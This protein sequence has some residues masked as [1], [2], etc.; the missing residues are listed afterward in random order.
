MLNFDIAIV[1]NNVFFRD[2]YN[3]FW[4]K[5]SLV[6]KISVSKLEVAAIFPK[7][8]YQMNQTLDNAHNNPA[9]GGVLIVW[10]VGHVELVFGKIKYS[11]LLKLVSPPFISRK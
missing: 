5:A 1:S 7:G 10:V 3:I 11:G 8:Y 4:I 9:F 2:G 6:E